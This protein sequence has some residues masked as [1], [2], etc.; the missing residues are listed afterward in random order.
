MLS[1]CWQWRTNVIANVLSRYWWLTALR[2]VLWVGFGV[3][4]FVQPVVSLVTLTLLFGAVVLVDGSIALIAGLAGGKEQ[5]DRW[6]L[7]LAGVVGVAV[8]ILTFMHPAMTGL[9]LLFYVALWAIAT[10]LLEIF[11][12]IRLRKEI[13]GEL[14]LILAGI[15]SVVFGVLILARPGTGALALLW[16]IASYAIVLG[17]AL[18]ALAFRARSFGRVVGAAAA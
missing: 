11:G 2:G 10:G 4:A 18:I 16:V 15:L 9:V 1:A 7:V 13:R 6:L 12:A 8:G 5:E 17:V 3:F 14:W